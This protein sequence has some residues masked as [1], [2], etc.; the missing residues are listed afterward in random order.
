VALKNGWQ[1]ADH[2]R[3]SALGEGSL[4]FLDE[5]VYR[6][7]E[8]QVEAWLALMAGRPFSE[9]A[10]PLLPEKDSTLAQGEQLRQPLELLLRL[11]ADLARMR[12]GEAPALAPWRE[13]LAALTQVSR[14][15]KAPQEAALEALRHLPRNLSPEPLIREV[16]LSLGA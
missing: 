12:T 14:D 13:V 15:L 6:R 5:A 3:W 11:L 2:D 4:R 1:E 8:A 16:A 9:V 7:A 10:G